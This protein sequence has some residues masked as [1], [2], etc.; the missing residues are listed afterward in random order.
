[1]DPTRNKKLCVLFKPDAKEPRRVGLDTHNFLLGVVLLQFFNTF[2]GS[3]GQIIQMGIQSNAKTGWTM[4]AL[5]PCDING[6]STISRALV[7]LFIEA[8][9]SEGIGHL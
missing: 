2:R 5:Q 3:M 7:L 8:N 6:R 9:A 4:G 1:M